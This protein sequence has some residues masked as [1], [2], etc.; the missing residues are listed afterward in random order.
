MSFPFEPGVNDDC[1]FWLWVSGF[2]TYESGCVHKV[3]CTGSH[4]LNDRTAAYSLSQGMWALTHLLSEAQFHYMSLIQ[5]R[6]IFL[7]IM[8]SLS[9]CSPRRK[10]SNL[11][12]KAMSL[13]WCHISF[14]A[15]GHS[16]KLGIQQLTLTTWSIAAS[17]GMSTISAR[18]IS[19]LPYKAANSVNHVLFD[20]WL[21]CVACCSAVSAFSCAV[22]KHRCAAI[23]ASCL[24]FWP[25]QSSMLKTVIVECTGGLAVRLQWLWL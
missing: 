13:L 11:W 3:T 17:D 15:L 8:L 19:W 9:A 14:G 5:V 24:S 21:W 4:L 18:L 1:T 23:A 6:W 20:K 22:R 2:E 10:C 12:R 7:C 25:W 16:F